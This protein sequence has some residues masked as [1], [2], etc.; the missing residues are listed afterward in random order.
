MAKN[1]V[2]FSDANWQS[3]VLGSDI[4]V[5]VDFWAVWCGP[6][7]ALTPT[8]AAV[9]EAYDGK[10]KV[11]KLNIDDHGQA[12]SSS[13]ITAVP[14]LALFKGGKEVGRLVGNQPKAKITA[15]IDQHL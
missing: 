11:G 15:L 10:V 14:T 2:E 8:V 4:P 6:C 13:S 3:E 9:A 7:R 12:A 1:M 5:L